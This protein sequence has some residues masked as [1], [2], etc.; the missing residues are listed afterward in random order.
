MIV[1]YILDIH[2]IPA[3]SSSGP[4]Q[5][6]FLQHGV[7]ESSGTWLVNPASR[8]LRIKWQIRRRFNYR[9]IS[10]NVSL[11]HYYWLI[12]LTTCGSVMSGA[13]GF[14]GDM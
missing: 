2:R 6:V 10:V 13:T 11:Q 7:A 1:R 3:K 5:V 9:L 14:P 12:N 8:S 4:K